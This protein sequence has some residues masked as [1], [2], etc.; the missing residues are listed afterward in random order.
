[1]I[2]GNLLDNA[3]EAGEKVA[4]PYIKLAVTQRN[5]SITIMIENRTSEETKGGIGKTT[6]KD[7]KNHGMGL[8]SV[9]RLVKKYGGELKLERETGIFRVKIIFYVP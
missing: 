5:N 2:L 7:K 1:M 9:E 8:Q 3:I 4:N 6:K